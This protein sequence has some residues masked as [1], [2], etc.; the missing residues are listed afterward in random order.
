MLGFYWEP[1]LDGDCWANVRVVFVEVVVRGV[2]RR[3]R[4]EVLVRVFQEQGERLLNEG[5][6]K[7]IGVGS[8]KEVI[9]GLEL[10]RAALIIIEELYSHLP[11]K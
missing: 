11:K 3:T 1:G 7:T 6:K 9:L 2:L 4:M 5:V 8:A 10:R